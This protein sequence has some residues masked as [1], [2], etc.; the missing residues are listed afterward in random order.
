MGPAR[1]CGRGL[2]SN[3][4]P[5]DIVISSSPTFSRR[6]NFKEA[7][8]RRS[9]EKLRLKK[10]SMEAE[11]ENKTVGIAEELTEVREVLLEESGQFEVEEEKTD[12]VVEQSSQVTEFV[13]ENHS[14]VVV[15]Q[16]SDITEVMVEQSTE[17]VLKE[18]EEQRMEVIAEQ[19][20]QAEAIVEEKIEQRMEVMVEQ[21]VSME[22][23]EQRTE[24]VVE[25][26]SIQAESVVEEEIEQ[27]T[28]IVVEQSSSQTESVVEDVAVEQSSQ[29]L[30]ASTREFVKED[31]SGDSVMSVV[32]SAGAE[33]FQPS[34]SGAPG[35]HIPDSLSLPLE[36]EAASTHFWTANSAR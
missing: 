22:E 19:S 31:P 21:S 34:P 35:R 3:G 2:E 26:S 29:V 7:A 20:S 33:N 16:S 25:Q 36:R 11:A 5:P 23:K 4:S 12:L 17:S 9:Q 10:L 13:E 6:K 30:A 14:E 18:E 8:R 15:Q 24:I 1:D 28:E 32:E 27:R